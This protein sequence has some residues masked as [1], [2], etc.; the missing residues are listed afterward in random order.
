MTVKVQAHT[1]KREGQELQ[2]VVKVHQ[3]H[4]ARKRRSSDIDD[5]ETSP[6]RERDTARNR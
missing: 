1:A 3:A 6:R 5:S 4:T 2:M